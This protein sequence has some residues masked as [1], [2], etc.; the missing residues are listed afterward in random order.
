MFSCTGE[1]KLFCR[2]T[3][4]AVPTGL[5]SF[6]SRYNVSSPK[7]PCMRASYYI[8]SIESTRPRTYTHTQTRNVQCA[9]AT[10]VAVATAVS[11]CLCVLQS[12]V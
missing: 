2:S 3:S 1:R 9:R 11:H 6:R 4:V 7:R 5:S 8:I 12:C 10:D